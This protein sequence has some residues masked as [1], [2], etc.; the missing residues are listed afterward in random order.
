MSINQERFWRISDP[1]VGKDHTNIK[2]RDRVNAC[3]KS[4]ILMVFYK[5]YC[6]ESQSFFK[7]FLTLCLLTPD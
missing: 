5:K 3:E 2:R 7:I 1:D 4:F 6:E